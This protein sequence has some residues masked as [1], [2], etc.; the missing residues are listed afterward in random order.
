VPA[1]SADPTTERAN[2][3]L[4]ESAIVP[5]VPIHRVIH[6][7]EHWLWSGISG[8]PQIFRTTGDALRTNRRRTAFSESA[9]GRAC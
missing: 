9:R 6:P 1:I 8:Y 3:F 5:M 7:A 4:L 2:I